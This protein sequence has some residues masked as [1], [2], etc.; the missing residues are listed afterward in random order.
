MREIP[1]DDL[2]FYSPWPRQMLQENGRTVGNRYWAAV[3]TEYSQKYGKL[4]DAYEGS[5]SKMTYEQLRDVELGNHEVAASLGNRLYATSLP[6]AMEKSLDCLMKYLR[7]EAMLVGSVVDLGCGY[8][9]LLHRLRRAVNDS[10]E[11][12]GGELTKPG[13]ELG[14]LL[15][16][17]IWRCDLLTDACAPLEH[18]PGPSV[19]TTSYVF[20]QLESARPAIDLLAKYREKIEVV[21]NLEPEEDHFGAGLLGLLRRRYGQINDYSADLNRVLAGRN[22]VKIEVVEPAV[23]GANALLPGTITVWRFV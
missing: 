16:A 15:G 2:P 8:G 10:V 4:L 12:W 7:P 14:N 13:V 18:V 1:L 3:V 21:I 19:V 9:Y 23:V 17:T 20:H 5:G 11:L 6:W 22:D